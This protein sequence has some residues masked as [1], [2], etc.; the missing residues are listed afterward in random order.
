MQTPKGVSQEDWSAI[1]DRCRRKFESIFSEWSGSSVLGDI[2]N[3]INDPL[4]FSVLAMLKRRVEPNQ[5]TIGVWIENDVAY[6]T[7]NPFFIEKL[8]KEQLEVILVDQT[9]K[10]LLK[11]ITTRLKKP[12]E[13][14]ML[15]SDFT[16][17]RFVKDTPYFT[18]EQLKE[19]FPNPHK[20]TL[21][22]SLNYEKYFSEVYDKY[23]DMENQL[24]EQYSM[25]GDKNEDGENESE[26]GSGNGGEKSE[27]EKSKPEFEK[28]END[29]DALK[30]HFSPENTSRQKWGKNLQVENELKQIVDN[31][32]KNSKN[33]GTV[34]GNHVEEIVAEHKPKLN[35]R[36][37]L[38]YF[39][40]TVESVT[41]KSSRM[42]VN[43]RYD[44]SSPGYRREYKSKLLF[45]IDTS[46]SVGNDE[47]KKAFGVVNTIFKNTQ[48]VSLQFD[49]EVVKIDKH[50]R[51]AKKTF[52]ANGRGGTDFSAVVNYIKNSNENF[53]GV[54]V[55]TD[56]YAPEPERIKI[57]WL[58]L[59]S[60]K[61]YSPPCDWGKV[62]HFEK[63]YQ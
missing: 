31:A 40:K 15:A 38:R 5:K 21:P 1:L 51:K 58:W 6:L 36:Q 63:E 49:T 55:F 20:Y 24:M 53:D 16:N 47:L 3:K 7:Y 59:M 27:Q 60:K 46:A 48:I 22:Q 13:F 34:T 2:N 25:S 8:Y 57:P 19:Y 35:Y 17:Y 30:K 61:E 14:S 43:R 50:F 33:W 32:E 45:A 11:H 41:Q 23:S 44:L 52:S 54:I 28:F 37:I 9:M 29:S 18:D 10:V 12:V 42:K 39:K 4:L 56:G 26:S 62:A